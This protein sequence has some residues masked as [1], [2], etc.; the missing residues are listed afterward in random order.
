MR[1]QAIAEKNIVDALKSFDSRGK[2]TVL[3]RPVPMQKLIEVWKKSQDLQG[4]PTF[5]HEGQIITVSDPSTFDYSVLGESIT[6][7][8]IGLDQLL[9]GVDLEKLGH[10]AFETFAWYSSAFQFMDSIMSIRGVHFIHKPAASPLV[11]ETKKRV[12][13]RPRRIEL[14]EIV[15]KHFEKPFLRAETDGAGWSFRSTLP[16]HEAR[17]SD[18]GKFLIALINNKKSKEIPDEVRDIYGYLKA[19]ADFK[20]H[21]FEWREFSI[22]LRNDG[23]FKSAILTHGKDIANIRHRAVYQNQTYDVF[24]YTMLQ[25]GR[26]VDE[27]TNVSRKFV[28]RFALAM[29]KWNAEMLGGIWSYLKNM[30]PYPQRA[31][32]W[33]ALACRYVPLWIALTE[34]RLE[35]IHAKKEIATIH[36]AIPNLITDILASMKILKFP[37]LE[38][39][40]VKLA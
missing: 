6:S 5:R 33:P 21:Q 19:V 16:S 30:R 31:L 26:K 14:L 22:K 34:V 9:V 28:K 2:E 35:K 13:G 1:D 10:H 25:Q 12:L 8:C 36:S 4:I 3:R 7:L 40:S 15:E 37:R 11:R 29:A 24:S 20:A 23:Q 32:D 38:K 17:W 27:F 18:F 39:R